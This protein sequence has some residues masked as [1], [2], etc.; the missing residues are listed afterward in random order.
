MAFGGINVTAPEG[1]EADDV[2]ATFAQTAVEQVCMWG[3]GLS[4][5]CL[6]RPNFYTHHHTTP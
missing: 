1:L 3:W 6:C 2:I 4:C 5:L